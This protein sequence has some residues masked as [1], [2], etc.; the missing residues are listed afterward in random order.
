MVRAQ[1]IIIR[2]H[3]ILLVRH[4]YEGKEWLCLVGGAVE[5]GE[6]SLE[7]ALRE[8]REECQVDGRLI[9]KT[10]E[11]Y[12]DDSTTITYWVDIDNQVPKVNRAE[13]MN[14]AILSV[15]WYRLDDISERDRA[16]IFAGRLLG[17]SEFQDEISRW[18][19]DI[20]YP[21]RAIK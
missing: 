17:I 6:T 20:S 15:G 9:R 13:M 21:T 2:D 12:E 5:D 19:D 11:W 10:A 14:E 16:I 8:L 4:R 7:A 1:C 18:S 3:K